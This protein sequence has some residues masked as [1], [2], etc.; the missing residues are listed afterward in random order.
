MNLTDLSHIIRD[1][2]DG[3]TPKS[4]SERIKRWLLSESQ[5]DE[6]NAVMKQIWDG[7]EPEEVDTAGALRTFRENRHEYEWNL[8]R[9]SRLAK[10]LRWAA[11]LALPIIGAAAAWVYSG[12]YYERKQLVEFYV[13]EGKV[14]SLMLSDGTKVIVNSK[15]TILYPSAFNIHGGQRDVFLLGEAHFKVAKDASRP[16]V[17]HSGKLN[18]QVLGT[19]FNVKAY[20]DEDLITTTLEEGRVK[21]YDDNYSETMK[22]NEQIVYSRNDGRM[23][24]HVVKVRDFNCWMLG[25]MVFREQTLGSILNELGS[26]YEV[27]F[28]VDSSIDLSQKYTMN[29]TN[30]ETINDVLRVLSQLANN[31]HYYKQGQTIKL[32]KSRKEDSL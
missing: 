26:R 2:F 8:H 20:S 3:I 28:V 10:T 25:T 19:Q 21:L 4:Y 30:K 23:A 22:P 31:L 13:P 27:D 15:T 17:V 1:Y 9:R 12:K 6:K 18:I 29:F 24:K 14:D 5:E 32:F 16:F 7:L 11:V